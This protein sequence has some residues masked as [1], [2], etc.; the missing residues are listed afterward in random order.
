MERHGEAL[1][2]IRQPPL[3]SPQKRTK[4]DI[5]G[6]DNSVKASSWHGRPSGRTWRLAWEPEGEGEGEEEEVMK[7]LPPKVV[8]RTNSP[9]RRKLVVRGNSF[10]TKDSPNFENGT[11]FEM[12]VEEP[13]DKKDKENDKDKEKGEEEE[14]GRE[15]DQQCEVKGKK[16]SSSSSSSSD[17]KA[18]GGPAKSTLDDKKTKLQ[19]DGNALLPAIPALVGGGNADTENAA[20]ALAMLQNMAGGVAT[21]AGGAGGMMVLGMLRGKQEE[22]R[23]QGG[24]GGVRGSEQQVPVLVKSDGT[25][26]PLSGELLSKLGVPW[27]AAV[28]MEGKGGRGGEHRRAAAGEEERR[29]ALWPEE[30]PSTSAARGVQGMNLNLESPEKQEEEGRK[31]E[32]PKK[33]AEVRGKS[34]RRGEAAASKDRD[35]VGELSR[36]DEAAIAALQELGASVEAW[37][38]S[39]E[40]GR[41]NRSSGS[42]QSPGTGGSSVNS[43]HGAARGRQVTRACPGCGERISI[44]CKFCALCGY[45]FRRPSSQPN[46]A[47]DGAASPLA[48]LAPDSASTEGG[49]GEGLELR[50]L[51]SASSPVSASSAGGSNQESRVSSPHVLSTGGGGGGANQAEEEGAGEEASVSGGGAGGT[52]RPTVTRVTANSLEL[53]KIKEQARRAREKQLL[54]RLQSLLFDQR[55]SPP[56]ASEVTYNFVLG[57]AVDALKDRFLRKGMSIA[58]L[59]L[60][61]LALEPATPRGQ[62]G[63]G[64]G[65]AEME[66]HK[67]KEQQRRARKRQLLSTLQSMVL[68]EAEATTKSSGITGNYILELVV[69][70]LEKERLEAPAANVAVKVEGD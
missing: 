29:R 14:E 35:K 65:N 28:P 69:V 18:A 55:D 1:T 25:K 63:G 22:E 36:A 56:S 2:E 45:T 24:D 20:A 7:G 59:G 46:S 33:G 41:R 43:R 13:E 49:A 10:E 21:G 11:I 52:P 62:E 66:K 3:A 68:G 16:A 19:Q 60:E 23:R 17:Q 31:E 58:H 42:L 12:E 9:T 51:S 39:E 38:S 26:I 34:T 44:A 67:I 4:L 6:S 57:C 64:S 61:E 48:A 53:H 30:S 27:L 40:A 47:K 8:A 32:A 37:E 50:K 70:E 5:F 15:E 54:A